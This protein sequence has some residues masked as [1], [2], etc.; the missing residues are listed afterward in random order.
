MLFGG[1]L[2]ADISS[3]SFLVYLRGFLIL[4]AGSPGLIVPLPFL[5]PSSSICCSILTCTNPIC[6]CEQ[7]SVLEFF[8]PLHKSSFHNGPKN[9]CIDPGAVARRGWG[10]GSCGLGISDPHP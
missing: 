9:N 6:R 10:H 7:A 8:G 5:S 3:T 2:K 1:E 4:R